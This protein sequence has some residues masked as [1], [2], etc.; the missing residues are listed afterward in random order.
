MDWQGRT[1]PKRPKPRLTN[2]RRKYWALR[3][4][5]KKEEDVEFTTRVVE[6]DHDEKEEKAPDAPAASH[7]RRRV[8]PRDHAS[9]RASDAPDVST[10]VDRKPR[11]RTLK[12]TRRVVSYKIE[13]EGYGVED[14]TWKTE[15]EVIEEGLEWMIRDYEMRIHQQG[16][17][18]DLGTACVFSPAMEGG[19]TRL[20]CGCS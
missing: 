6:Q 14:A 5:D 13:W 11:T 17:E 8:S 15:E 4:I 1:Q 19:R 10:R 12:E 18:L 20:C 9:T 16:D 3:I 7:Q 2:G